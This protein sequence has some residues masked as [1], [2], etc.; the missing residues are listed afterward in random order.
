MK[1]LFKRLIVF[2][3]LYLIVA[4]G[5]DVLLP[6]YYGNP[7]FGSKIEYLEKNCKKNGYNAFFIGSSRFY[8]NVNPLVFDRVCANN[9]FDVKSFN[10]GAPITFP[11]QSYY[12][13]ENWLMSEEATHTKLVFLELE[14]LDMFGVR[15]HTEMSSYHIT[16]KNLFFV[17]R[18]INAN[19][20]L[21]I[22]LKLSYA[23]K[24]CIS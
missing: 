15:L 14:D 12:L 4:R 11:P 16:F 13:Y 9:G 7:W 23:Y 20:H 18:S 22:P 2:I 19:F 24:Y 8:R 10:L 3:I 17:L 5:I 1:K 6:Y 21:P